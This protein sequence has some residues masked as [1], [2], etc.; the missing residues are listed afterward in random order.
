MAGE[1]YLLGLALKREPSP[2]ELLQDFEKRELGLRHRA[3]YVLRYPENVVK[4]TE[5]N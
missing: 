1:K 5:I 3:F 2:E 4:L